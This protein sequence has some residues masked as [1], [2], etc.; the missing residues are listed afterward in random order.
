LPETL[1]SIV[2]TT[3]RNQ[4]FSASTPSRWSRLVP[5]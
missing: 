1:P 3:E 2:S 5:S 4:V